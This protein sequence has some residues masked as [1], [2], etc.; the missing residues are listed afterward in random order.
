M[1]VEISTHALGRRPEGDG[2]NLDRHLVPYHVKQGESNL[3]SSLY[4][5]LYASSAVLMHGI[6]I[7]ALV[8]VRKYM[9]QIAAN[10][11][12]QCCVAS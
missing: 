2:A 11:P 8:K 12:Q 9:Q 4:I 1:P 5:Y 3:A 6:G 10:F 7:L